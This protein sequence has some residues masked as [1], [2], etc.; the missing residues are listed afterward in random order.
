MDAPVQIQAYY[1][2]R[3][4][5]DRIARM[6]GVHGPL[7]IH[8]ILERYNTTWSGN[9]ITMSE[10]TGILSRDKRFKK[11]GWLEIIGFSGQKC[12]STIWKRTEC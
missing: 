10:L 1:Q 6:L 3:K 8:M 12:K 5:K 4:P 2:V 9:G 7:S 11:D